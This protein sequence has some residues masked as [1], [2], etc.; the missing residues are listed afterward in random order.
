MSKKIGIIGAGG[1]LQYHAA[2][3]TA[4]GGELLAVCDMNEKAAQEAAE[5][6]E[7][8][9]VF[10]DSSKMLEE[11]RELDAISI[12]TPNKTHCPLAV[13]ALNAGKDVFCEKP[14]P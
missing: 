1:M 6:Y 4:G 8:P 5:R 3:F 2:G 10:G 9:K 7:I 12:I 13:Q 11:L 14:R